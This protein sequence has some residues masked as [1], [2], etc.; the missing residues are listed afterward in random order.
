MFF[1]FCLSF[2]WSLFVNVNFF[3]SNFCFVF[4]DFYY[5]LLQYAILI[6]FWRWSFFSCCISQ[7]RWFVGFWFF[8][9]VLFPD[10][11]K[12]LFRIQLWFQYSVEVLK[13]INI[14]YATLN[15]SAGLYRFA[16][17]SQCVVRKS[18]ALTK[19]FETRNRFA[20]TVNFEWE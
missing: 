20:A 3:F 17:S 10:L 13:F 15:F 4:Y 1:F 9:F 14:N 11:Y 18:A 7:I 2:D 6:S 16:K 12:F 8:V 19:N 5:S